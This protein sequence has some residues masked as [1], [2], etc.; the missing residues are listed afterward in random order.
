MNRQTI[1]NEA[2]KLSIDNNKTLI[3]YGTGTGKTLISIRIIESVGGFWNIVIAE[4]NHELNWI[5]EFKKHNKEHLLNNVRFFCYQSFHKYLKENNYILDEV[6]HALSTPKR[7]ELLSSIGKTASRIVGLSATVSK[8]QKENLELCVGK[9]ETVK[10]TVSNAIEFDILP[11]PKVYFVGIDLNNTVKKYKFHFNKDKY[12][13]C[14]EKEYYNR[15]SDRIEYFKE[16]FML[17]QNYSDK[18]KWLRTANERKKFMAEVKTPYAKII[19]HKLRD[20]RL[21]CFSS[22]IKQ[23]EELG[24]KYSINS[25]LSKEKQDKLISDFNNLKVSKLYAVGMLREGINLTNIEAGLIIQ[26]DNNTKMFSQILGRC[27]R[28]LKDPTQYVL[29]IKDTQDVKYTQTA[30]EDFNMD[31]VEFTTIGKIK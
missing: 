18:I 8:K 14:T 10:F 5:E 23:S 19:L 31:Y 22:S 17:Y 11:E 9:Y 29:Y 6:H 7:L 16:K 27:L 12:I 4:R 20:K 3:E 25:K 15:I 26:L 28:N 13:M 2:V 30:L 1:Q 21:I 24:A